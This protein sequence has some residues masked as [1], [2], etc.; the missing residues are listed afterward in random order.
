MTFRTHT[1]SHTQSGKFPCYGRILLPVTQIKKLRPFRRKFN[2]ADGRI[3]ISRTNAQ[4]SIYRLLRRYPSSVF[5]CSMC[6][7]RSFCHTLGV[8]EFIQ[9]WWRY[10]WNNQTFVLTGHDWILESVGV[11][12]NRVNSVGVCCNRINPSKPQCRTKEIKLP[13]C[14]PKQNNKIW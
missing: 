5:V 11:Y 13:F 1:H 12:I 8:F 2:K 10:Q 14:L 4:S 6:K 3:D 7:L 9:R